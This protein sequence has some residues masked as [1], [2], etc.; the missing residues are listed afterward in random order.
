[1]LLISCT[2]SSSSSGDRDDGEICAPVGDCGATCWRGPGARSEQLS[3]W[4]EDGGLP[5]PRPC[6][7]ED[8]AQ[9]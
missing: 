3:R 9:S 5:T 4:W 2:S 7:E 1:M 8:A 6:G